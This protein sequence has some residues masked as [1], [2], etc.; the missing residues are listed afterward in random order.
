MTCHDALALLDDFVDGELDS[1][2]AGTVRNHI[3]NCDHCRKEYTATKQLKE[4]LQS[5]TTEDPGRDYWSETAHLIMARTVETAGAPVSEL[6]RVQA[7]RGRSDFVRSMVSLAASIAI[8][9]SAIFVGENHQKP[10]MAGGG[11]GG[12]PVFL[13]QSV[14]L[15]LPSDY[16]APATASYER[17]L[18]RG[19]ML[20]GAPGHLSRIAL[21]AEMSAATDRE[22]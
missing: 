10:T 7:G 8:L 16:P 14:V 2:I 18:A 22:E 13:A 4:L 20:L 19:M 21:L 5:T 6:S 12:P 1:S 11:T 9:I 17:S 15:Q 3:N